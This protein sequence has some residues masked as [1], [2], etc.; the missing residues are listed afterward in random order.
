M[1]HTA[2]QIWNY[3]RRLPGNKS[4]VRLWMWKIALCHRLSPDFFYGV[5]KCYA[6]LSVFTGYDAELNLLLSAA[7]IATG[8]C[9]R[10]D[11]P[12]EIVS[13]VRSV[14]IFCLNR[15]VNGIH[16]LRPICKM[17]FDWTRFYK[18]WLLNGLI[19]VWK[20]EKFLRHNFGVLSREARPQQVIYFSTENIW[21]YEFILWNSFTF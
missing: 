11:N 6:Q 2:Y 20:S 4:G 16:K 3:Y 8:C 19:R 1:A 17:P 15:N 13:P 21:V 18:C 12:V 10:K 14:F 5:V 7:E 9:R